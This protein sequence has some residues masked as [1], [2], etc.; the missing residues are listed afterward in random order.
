MANPKWPYHNRLQDKM[1]DIYAARRKNSNQEESNFIRD[2]ITRLSTAY[3]TLKR[4]LT[5]GGMVATF[6]KGK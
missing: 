2:N 4:K 3:N 1:G 5:S 6:K